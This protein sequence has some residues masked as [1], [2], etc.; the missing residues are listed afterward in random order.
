MLVVEI[1]VFGGPHVLVPAERP[2]P[3]PGPGE[4]LIRHR[5]IGLNFIDAYHRSG[6]YPTP[7]PAIL[8]SEA[9]GVVEAVGEGVR[10]F[11]PGDRVAYAQAGGGGA[12]AEARTLPADRAVPIPDGVS[13]DVAAAAMLKGMTAEFLLR[14]CFTVS[15]GDTILVH[16]AA[17]GVGGLLVQW[18]KALGAQVIGTAG[19]QDKAALAT[20]LGADA[21]ILYREQ[22]V[23]QR[24]RELTGGEGVAVVYDS[25][26]KD[27]LDGSLASLRRR[28]WLVSF[29]NAS[30]PPPPLD[31]LRLMRGGSL[32][33]TRPTLVD[34]IATVEELDASASAVFAAI[35]SGAL[36]PRIGQR[37]ALK[38]AA[39]AHRALEGRHTTGATVLI[40]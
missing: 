3:E 25:V 28:G 5:A 32:I 16:A 13:D 29:G 11:K 36:R 39:D 14:R 21:V 27:T 19:S 22:D 24:V 2:T 1:H 18:A 34:Y 26:G 17:G 9:A 20:D 10:R 30:G 33:L 35:Q 37:F 15:P 38:D 31:P 40:P 12:Y 23:A 6:L 7:L 4:L 8:G